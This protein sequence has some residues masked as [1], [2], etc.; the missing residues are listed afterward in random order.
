M[1]S[2]TRRF[3]RIRR[4]HQIKSLVHFLRESL[5]VFG[6]H[7]AVE[8]INRSTRDQAR[9]AHHCVDLIPHHGGVVGRADADSDGPGFGLGGGMSDGH[10]MTPV[11]S[12]GDAGAF[13]F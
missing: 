7:F 8:I 10:V 1:T 13:A 5:D 11:L 3:S 6:A 4:S 12:R 2:A 9:Y